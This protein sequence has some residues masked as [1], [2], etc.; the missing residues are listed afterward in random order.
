[1]VLPYRA[2]KCPRIDVV[3]FYDVGTKKTGRKTAKTY[4]V[5][6]YLYANCRKEATL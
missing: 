4:A 6:C 5:F 2:A 1:M 3:A